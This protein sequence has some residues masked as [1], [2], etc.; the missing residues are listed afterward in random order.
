ME[1]S[2]ILKGNEHK[3]CFEQKIKHCP[4]RFGLV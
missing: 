4:S 3:N 1:R 2:D